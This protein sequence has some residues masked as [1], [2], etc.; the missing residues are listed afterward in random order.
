[1]T[2]TR[3]I[4]DLI[5]D[6]DLYPRHAV[7]AA[8]VS[9]LV[10]AIESGADLPPVVIDADTNRIVDGWHRARAH[11]R[12]YGDDAAI[13]VEAR[14]YSSE[15]DVI[16]DAVAANAG[17]G[18][19]FDSQDRTR[20]ALMLQR[21]GFDNEQV[22]RTLNIT[23]HRVEQATKKVAVVRKKPEPAKPIAW[24]QDGKV[25]KLN[26][27]QAEVMRSSSGWRPSQTMRQ[28]ARELEVGLV[29]LDDPNNIDALRELYARCSEALASVT[30]ESLA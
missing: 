8:H 17:H 27:R 9:R 26:A 16:A 28:L 15:A 7:D 3:L 19:P 4:A 22:A 30:Q 10:A 29:D 14:H 2:E 1:M 25:R 18:R 5:E 21:A 13:T 23:V 12:A 24:P 11:R 20:A 6:P